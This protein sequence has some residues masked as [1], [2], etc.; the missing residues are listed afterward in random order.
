MPTKVPTNKLGAEL[1]WTPATAGDVSK[2]AD[3]E[4]HIW[5]VD[6]SL[7]PNQTEQ[8]LSWLNARQRD[9]YQRRST[10]DMQHA[11]LAGRYYLFALL[12]AYC[13]VSVTEIALDYS[14]L[15][16]PFLSP[17]PQNLSFNFT[18]ST[19]PSGNL[20]LYAFGR[21]SEV[22]VDI[23]SRHRRSNFSLVA[24][25]KFAPQ[26]Q[27]MVGLKKGRADPET[28]LALWTRKEAYGKA[29]G[30][31]VNFKMSAL[32]L[33]S[34]GEHS[35]CFTGLADEQRYQLQQFTVGADHIACVVY[36]GEAQ[37]IS[38]FRTKA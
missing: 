21:T 12:S 15:G 33:A 32:N 8:A 28:F 3:G 9:K 4:L 26:E 5:A 35:L 37:T 25:R 16:K 18:D 36:A 14:R 10:P 22:G 30:Q 20:G 7:N 6:L 11:Y 13:G 19:S 17:N 23:E 38:A 24:Q 1:D 31:G 27:D 34:P 2:L 29:I